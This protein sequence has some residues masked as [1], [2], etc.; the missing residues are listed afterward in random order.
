MCRTAATMSTNGNPIGRPVSS[1]SAR[2]QP[3]PASVAVP[4]DSMDSHAGARI[5]ANADK[6]P[7]GAL[8]TGNSFQDPLK[9][10]ALSTLGSSQASLTGVI[11]GV[12]ENSSGKI[13]DSKK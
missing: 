9:N 1:P 7:A 10:A 4:H 6:L 8:T 5:Q 3:V 12:L 13:I 11:N 2:S